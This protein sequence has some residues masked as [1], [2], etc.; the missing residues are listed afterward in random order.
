[1]RWR[2]PQVPVQRRRAPEAH[3]GWLAPLA[4]AG[5][6][7]WWFI[8]GQAEARGLRFKAACPIV[9]QPPVAE[10]LREQRGQNTKL[11]ALQALISRIWPSFFL[12]CWPSAHKQ[13]IRRVF[14]RHDIRGGWA[15][16]VASPPMTWR[17]VAGPLLHHTPYSQEHDCS[18]ASSI[19]TLASTPCAGPSF[20]PKFGSKGATQ[21]LRAVVL[22]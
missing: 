12:C 5:G 13:H 22:N 4:P 10:Q 1:M 6:C 7:G 20:G 15:A 18:L 9:R 19:V 11:W 16:L 8:W 3:R 21:Y 2:F 17:W 14:F